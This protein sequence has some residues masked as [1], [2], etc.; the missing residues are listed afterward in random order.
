MCS[1]PTL[2][3]P[4]AK[5]VRAPTSF[6]APQEEQCILENVVLFG[7]L[8]L[9]SGELSRLVLRLEE[10]TLYGEI[11]NSGSLWLSPC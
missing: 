6:T 3:I 1:P 7:P 5:V 4:V 9:P 8:M 11:G 10:G 2:P